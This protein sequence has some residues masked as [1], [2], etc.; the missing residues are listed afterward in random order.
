MAQY[1]TSAHRCDEIVGQVLR[2]L[3]ETG[4]EKTR[5]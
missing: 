1:Y 2:A 4:F 5:W 3:K